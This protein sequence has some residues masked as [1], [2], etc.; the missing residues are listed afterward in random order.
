MADGIKSSVSMCL[1]HLTTSKDIFGHVDILILTWISQMQLA[2]FFLDVRATD[3]NCNF[4]FNIKISHL[5][6]WVSES[7]GNKGTYLSILF[8]LAHLYKSC[9]GD[10]DSTAALV[11]VST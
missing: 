10:S 3:Q 1:P 5:K 6:S 4:A 2:K 8:F 7:L 11:Y 9:Q